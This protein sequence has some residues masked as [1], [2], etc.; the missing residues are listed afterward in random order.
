MTT[1]PT[2]LPL[3]RAAVRELDRRAIEKLGIPGIVLMENAARGVA[4]VARRLLD[5]RRGS[6]WIFCGAGN[7][8]GDGYAMARWF[9]IFG[10]TVRV[11]GFANSRAQ[12]GDAARMRS[13]C[14]QLGIAEHIVRESAELDA[15]ST[16]L[17]EAT[18]IVDALLGTGFHGSVRAPYDLAIRAINSAHAT[19][20]VPIVA[21]DLP[22]GLDADTG[23]ADDA[24][25]RASL[26]ATL[27]APKLGFAAPGALEFTGRVEV[28]G[29][30]VPTTLVDEVR[31]EVR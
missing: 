19:S 29:I 25:V 6:V 23:V 1:S 24:T 21:V 9:T 26:T 16:E 27:V 18:L 28:V 17:A 14:M 2:T 8:G 30:G 5:G 15:L 13:I 31:A 4:E 10:A 12:R 20:N 22:S 7:N 3:S 11:V